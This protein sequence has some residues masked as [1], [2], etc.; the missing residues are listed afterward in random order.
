MKR[1]NLIFDDSA[2]LYDLLYAEKNTSEEVDWV[3]SELRNRGLEDGAR[4]LEIGSGTGR[5]A[6]ILAQLGFS[7]TA[8]EPSKHMLNRAPHHDRISYVHSD[9]ASLELNDAYDAV[10]ALFHVFSYQENLAKASSFF[11]SV[12]K[13]LKTGGL[14]GFD[15]WYSPAVL[16]LKPERRVLGK[17]TDLLRVNRVATPVENIPESCV[18]VHYRYA[19]EDKDSGRTKTFEEMHRMRHYTKGEIQL[20]A[21]A[22]GLSILGATEFMSNREPNRDTWGVWFTLQKV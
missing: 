5:H 13:H 19:I 12:S 22:H 14:F 7:V 6:Q 4:I 2:S 17:E 1:N 9:A 11:D 3:I 21:S 18:D 16:Y 8:V 20:L 15:V 10:L